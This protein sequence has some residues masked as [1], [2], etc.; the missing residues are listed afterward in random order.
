MFIFG[1]GFRTVKRF[2]FVGKH[3]CGAC[4]ADTGWQL[5]KV[6][7]WF[8]LFFIPI[9]PT[10]IKR[11][12]ICSQCNAGRIINKELFNQLAMKVQQ[13][14]ID[15]ETDLQYQ[16]KTETQKNYLEEMEAYRKSQ[17]EKEKENQ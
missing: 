8:T 4:H 2:G 17:E 3:K 10:S 5:V 13:G 11:M 7:T 1:W 12:I 6:T 16:N 9:I 15:H 14:D